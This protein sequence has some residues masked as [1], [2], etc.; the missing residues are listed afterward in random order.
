[1]PPIRIANF[2]PALVEPIGDL[3]QI[4][5][6]LP[7]TLKATRS[8]KEAADN[9]GVRAPPAYWCL[10][11]PEHGTALVPCP[12]AHVSRQINDAGVKAAPLYVGAKDCRGTPWVWVGAQ[13]GL[14]GT[15][16]GVGFDFR[17]RVFLMAVC[18]YHCA[19]SP[20]STLDDRLLMSL[21]CI[22]DALLLPTPWDFARSDCP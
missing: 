2:S 8:L 18:L 5:L 13:L 15:R 1:M 14:V 4:D 20:I 11:V 3:C 17:G 21:C 12:L 22:S 16:L 19:F 10:A 6:A 9:Q 7:P